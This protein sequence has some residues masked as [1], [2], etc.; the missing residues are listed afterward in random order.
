MTKTILIFGPTAVGKTEISIALTNKINGE[1]ISA[2]SMQVYRQMDIGTAKPTK[3]QRRKIPHYLIDVVDP[4]EEWT[5]SDF[6]ESTN[7]LV[8]EIKEKGKT[9]IIVGGTGLYL[10]AFINGYS[11]PI[12]TKD[13]AIRKRLEELETQTLYSRLKDIDPDAATKINANDKKRI[14]RALEVYEQTGIPI[15]RLQRNNAGIDRDRHLQLFCLIMDRSLLYDRINQ[16]VDKMIKD[17]L[18]DEV[19]SLL[20]KGYGKGLNSMQALGYKEIA[21]F[22]DG[23]ISF[24]CAVELI[25]RKTR[26]FARRQLT[27]FRKF[28]GVFNFD[29]Q[30][31]PEAV[32]GKLVAQTKAH[33]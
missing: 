7:H 11:F 2:D 16:R 6:I 13:E 26:N 22:L 31:G 21:S 30:E 9:P 10:N 24:D 4:D 18:I 19:R 27:W 33:L 32:A 15:S 29:V 17:G 1:I 20:K 25:K 14:I 12:A 8:S 3:E 23:E 28:K 5:V